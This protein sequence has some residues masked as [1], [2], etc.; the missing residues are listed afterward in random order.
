MAI[1]IPFANLLKSFDS[2]G[3]NQDFFILAVRRESKENY[4]FITDKYRENKVG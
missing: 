2:S 3:G 1:S 4:L